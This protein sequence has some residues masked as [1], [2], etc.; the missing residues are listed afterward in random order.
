MRTPF[1]NAMIWSLVLGWCGCCMPFPT[2]A[3]YAQDAPKTSRCYR[4][5]IEGMTCKECAINVKKALANAPG[6]GEAKVNYVKAEASVCAKP[7]TNIT[8]EAL[9]KVVEKAGYKAKVKRQS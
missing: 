6:T 2:S 1:K 5:A 4:L 7:G 9:V 8:A 3:L